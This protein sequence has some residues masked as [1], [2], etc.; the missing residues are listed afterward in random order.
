MSPTLLDAVH[1]DTTLGVVQRAYLGTTLLARLRTNL[2]LRPSVEQSAGGWM[3]STWGTGG[4]GTAGRTVIADAPSGQ[5]V[6]KMT[7]TTGTTAASSPYVSTS[8]SATN[9]VKVEPGKEYRVALY[10]RLSLTRNIRCGVI[11]HLSDGTGFSSQPGVTTLVPAN[12]W[13][14][15]SGPTPYIPK[16]TFTLARVTAEIANASSVPA[17]STFEVDA[18]MFE[19]GTDL[20]AY[21]DGDTPRASWTGTPGSSTSTLWSPPT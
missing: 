8:N 5:A 18:V 14:R 11:G 19:E 16:P 2:H 9:H 4:A 17:G 6:Y 21:F 7:W 13:T 3:V 12:T 15:L 1:V 10:V 20:G